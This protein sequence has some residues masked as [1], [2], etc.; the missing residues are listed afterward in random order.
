[1]DMELESVDGDDE[2]N[3]TPITSLSSAYLQRMLTQH[4]IAQNSSNNATASPSNQDK[5]TVA[6][7]Q[8]PLFRPPSMSLFA[9]PSGMPTSTAHAT[10]APTM[11]S[12][13][14]PENPLPNSQQTTNST[15]DNVSL[16]STVSATGRG[17]HKMTIEE[18]E[19]ARRVLGL[20]KHRPRHQL[21]RSR[22]HRDKLATDQPSN[23]EGDMVRDIENNLDSHEKST[24]MSPS[25][26]IQDIN[27]DHSGLNANSAAGGASAASASGTGGAFGG[28]RGGEG[29]I[30]VRLFFPLFPLCASSLTI[31]VFY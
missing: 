19:V 8:F 16:S 29:I 23:Q 14:I 15:A 26:R 21:A 1:M 12:H 20:R 30:N 7:G 31:D 28:M 3:V 11:N 13:F 17:M 27:D 9:R 24:K 4:I 5:P 6:Q 2:D 22:S 18:E 25:R 10:S